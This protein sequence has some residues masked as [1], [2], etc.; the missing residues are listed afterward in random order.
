MCDPDSRTCEACGKVGQ[1]CC[2]KG[3]KC[4]KGGTCGRDGVCREDDPTPPCGGLN[5]DCCT[6][7]GVGVGGTWGAGVMGL[8]HNRVAVPGFNLTPRVWVVVG[9]G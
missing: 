8:K 1:P 2:G 9:P 3:R 5:Q 6:G 4:D 7:G